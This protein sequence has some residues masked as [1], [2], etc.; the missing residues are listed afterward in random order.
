MILVALFGSA[1][2]S[3]SRT[4]RYNLQKILY[5]VDRI[6]NM[7]GAFGSSGDCLWN[8]LDTKSFMLYAINQGARRFVKTVLPSKS[9]TYERKSEYL[10]QG[11]LT[12]LD[13]T[14]VLDMVPF[15][16]QASL[17]LHNCPIIP[18]SD[19]PLTFSDYDE[20]FTLVKELCY[21]GVLTVQD[22]DV[23]YGWFT[24]EEQTE[25]QA[26]LSNGKVKNV[27]GDIN[28]EESKRKPKRRQRKGKPKSS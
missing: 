3:T 18:I 20:M 8:V 5:E 9:L 10:R 4:S 6:A 14:I 19:I 1:E 22:F 7:R 27:K 16:P 17:H 23:I 2:R 15:G 21:S 24:G 11:F 12:S 26:I 13:P 28:F 25:L